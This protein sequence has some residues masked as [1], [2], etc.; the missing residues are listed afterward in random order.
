MTRYRGGTESKEMRD[1]KV[2]VHLGRATIQISVDW[3]TFMVEAK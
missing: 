3:L 1:N 2:K